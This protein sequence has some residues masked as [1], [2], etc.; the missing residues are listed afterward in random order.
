MEEKILDLYKATNLT[1][2][3][4]SLTTKVTNFNHVPNIVDSFVLIPF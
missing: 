2:P 4:V 3:I 1:L